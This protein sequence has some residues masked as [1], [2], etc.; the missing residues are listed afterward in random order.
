[1]R[2]NFLN[3]IL[4]NKEIIV[5]KELLDLWH[6]EYKDNIKEQK[7][8]ES[9]NPDVSEKLKPENGFRMMAIEAYELLWHIPPSLLKGE[10]NADG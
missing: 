4:N 1:M 6:E 5:T 9:K 7:D 8:F 2:T 3:N 10:R